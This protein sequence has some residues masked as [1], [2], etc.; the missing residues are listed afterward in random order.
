MPKLKQMLAM[1]LAALGLAGPALACEGWLLD[2]PEIHAS[3]LCVPAAPKRVVV[4]DASFGLSVGMDVGLPIV[5]AP[6]DMMSDAALKARATER[7]VT[8]TAFGQ[9]PASKPSSRLNRI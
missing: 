3:P 1:A 6:L 7:G 9:S 8:R 4:L 5:G 2:A